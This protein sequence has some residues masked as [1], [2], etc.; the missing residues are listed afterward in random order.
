MAGFVFA[1]YFRHFLFQNAFTIYV[2]WKLK[3]TYSDFISTIKECGTSE[4]LKL[5]LHLNSEVY[6]GD[7][8]NDF[9]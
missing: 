1:N 5:K 4:A 7:L 8:Y 9:G 6:K 3:C 2:S